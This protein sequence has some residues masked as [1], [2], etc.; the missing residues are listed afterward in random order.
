MA[1]KSQKNK[2]QCKIALK[3]KNANGRITAREY[4]PI[5]LML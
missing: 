5:Y 4:S 3:S 1:M 2:K